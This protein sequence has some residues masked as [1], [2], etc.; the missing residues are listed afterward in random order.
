MA[1]WQTLFSGKK[2]LHKTF[3]QLMHSL[4]RGKYSELVDVYYG[5]C[6]KFV[7]I[8]IID[9]IRDLC[10]KRFRVEMTI[11]QITTAKRRARIFM[12][13]NNF[14]NFNILKFSS[15]QSLRFIMVWRKCQYLFFSTQLCVLWQ[16]SKF[17]PFW[18]EKNK[19]GFKYYFI[20]WKIQK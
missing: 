5:I 9:I 13:L 8:T 4:K 17:I 10:T 14:F 11:L 2:F 15:E 3:L 6:H 1:G 7:I 19:K 12:L 18:S 20:R 16:N